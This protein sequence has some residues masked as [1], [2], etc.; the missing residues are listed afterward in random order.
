MSEV[1]AV[2]LDTAFAS[3][4]KDYSSFSG[5]CMYNCVSNVIIWNI[6]NKCLILAGISLTKNLF[7]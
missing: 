3:A 4:K 6:Y 1:M 2:S 5:I 7:V